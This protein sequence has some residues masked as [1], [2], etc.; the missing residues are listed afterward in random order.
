MSY[1]GYCFACKCEG[2]SLASPGGRWLAS[3]WRVGFGGFSWVARALVSGSSLCCQ[4][5]C[6]LHE[7]YNSRTLGSSRCFTDSVIPHSPSLSVPYQMISYKQCLACKWNPICGFPQHDFIPPWYN[8]IVVCVP[9]ELKFCKKSVPDHPTVGLI[10][11]HFGVF[12]FGIALLPPN[13]INKTSNRSELLVI[14]PHLPRSL[15]PMLVSA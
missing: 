14:L 13:G 3:I 8:T 10:P 5:S 6:R 4:P 12:Q 11:M 7:G 1:A 2:C 9:L 15:H